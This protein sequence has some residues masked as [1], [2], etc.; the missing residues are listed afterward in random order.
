MSGVMTP[1]YRTVFKGGWDLEMA[2]VPGAEDIPDFDPFITE[3]LEGKDLEYFDDLL[4]STRAKL[5]ATLAQGLE[6]GETWQQL[7]DRVKEVYKGQSDYRADRI[8]RTEATDAQNAASQD[9]RTAMKV[10]YKEWSAIFVNTRDTH[11]SANGQV[12]KNDGYFN[13]GDSVLFRP[14]DFSGSPAETVNCN[15]T[16]LGVYKNKGASYEVKFAHAVIAEGVQ[17]RGYASM[18]TTMSKSFRDQGKREL[19]A[20]DK[21]IQEQEG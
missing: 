15:C 5:S 1:R 13:V 2:N 18:K 14:G 4:A 10:P 12:V 7:R 19:A 17:S 21:L 16:A 6:A 20:F 8:A 11:A 3:Y 9:V